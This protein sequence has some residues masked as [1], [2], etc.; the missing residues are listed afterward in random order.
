VSRTL[1]SLWSEVRQRLES[2]GVDTPVLDARLL[3][4]AGAN[5]ARLDIVTDPR[6][7]VSEVE[8]KRVLALS[9]RR[10]AR[11]P[12]SHILGRKAFWSLDL[13]VTRDV[14]TPRPETE[15]LVEVA[16]AALPLEAPARVLDFG[17]GSGAVV[18]A[19]LS[20]RSL[21]SGVGVDISP[22]ALEVA[23]E[24]AEHL[25]LAERARFVESDWAE[26]VDG[27][28]DVVVSNPPY[29]A[30]SDIA[31]LAP[32]V[33]Q[34]EPHLALDGGADG[35]EAYRALFAATPR[36]LKSG[37]LF[38]FEVGKGQADSVKTMAAEAGFE[39]VGAARDLASVER[40]VFGRAGGG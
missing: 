20:E 32:E 31:A 34:Y 5:V 33:A 23:R 12:L 36:L 38:A 14:L 18:L 39:D 1:V 13:A 7:R 8:V 21:A 25:G 15:L 10:E 16:L 19:I 6:R 17:V 11:E 37:G 27:R 30:S 22:A 3:L 40:V 24:N 28:F 29:V 35:L 9:A 26:N 2:A 4:E